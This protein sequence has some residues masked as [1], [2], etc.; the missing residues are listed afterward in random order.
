M[1]RPGDVRRRHRDRVVLLRRA[2]R[3]GVEDARLLPAREDPRLHL[4]GGVAR[5]LLEAVR[6]SSATAPSATSTGPVASGTIA[7]ASDRASA[8]VYWHASSA[9]PRLAPRAPDS[10][11][12]RS[13]QAELGRRGSAERRPP[14]GALERTGANPLVGRRWTRVLRALR[15]IARAASAGRASAR[16]S[17]STLIARSLGCRPA[18]R[19]ARRRHVPTSGYARLAREQAIAACADFEPASASL[20]HAHRARRRR[21]RRRRD[22][23]HARTAPA[24]HRRPR[25]LPATEPGNLATLG[26]ASGRRS[27]ARL[28]RRRRTRSRSS[29]TPEPWHGV[30]VADARH[31]ARCARP[32]DATRRALRATAAAAPRRRTDVGGFAVRVASIER[33]ARHEA[34]RRPSEGPARPSS[35]LAGDRPRLSRG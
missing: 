2:L 6:R 31:D 23:G 17:T 22:R 32:P 25:H 27:S 7:L 3:L 16:A 20:G 30:E 4:R 21:R 10:R 19:L 34:R 13:A 18:E 14:I 28:A 24:R 5:A 15:A 1:K 12:R 33:P 9:R 11:R 8:A 29:R 35:E 26:E